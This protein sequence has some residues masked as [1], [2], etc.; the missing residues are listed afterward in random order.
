MEAIMDWNKQANEMIKSWSGTQQ[1]VW[2]MW[3]TSVQLMSAPQQPEAWQKSVDSWRGTVK[4]A[5]GAQVELT[6]M[7]AEAVASAAVSMPN[8]PTMPG[9]PSM[10]TMPGMLNPTSP[11]AMVDWSRQV[12]EM[13]RN[14]SES[15]QRFMD[16][17]FEMLKKSD[18][19][20]MAA[21]WDATQ[22]QQAM[23]VW[24]EAA[25]RMLE[26]QTAMAAAMTGSAERR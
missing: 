21:Q 4:H 14:W 25:Q 24:Q 18:P 13:T 15:Q 19:R 2:D 26:A 9:M 22:A 7:W 5:L 1:Q 16:G 10:P 17:W 8:M 23:K 6:R 3:M 20:T 12:L 11:T